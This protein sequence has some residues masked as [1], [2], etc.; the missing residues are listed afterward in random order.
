MSCKNYFIPFHIYPVKGEIWALYMDCNIATWASNP[1]NY[2][3]CKYEIVEVLDTDDSTGSTSIAYLDKM[4]GFV[5][6]FQQRRPNENDSFVINRSDIFRFSHKVP[7]FKKTGDSKRQG[8]PEGSFELDP[9][10]LPDDL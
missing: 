6:L 7:S 8:V 5:S 1:V 10:A 2:K 4:V 3:N 9:K